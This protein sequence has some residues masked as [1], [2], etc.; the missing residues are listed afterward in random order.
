MSTNANGEQ[1]S[2]NDLA[3]NMTIIFPAPLRVGPDDPDMR[4]TDNH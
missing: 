3:A 4:T 2:Y 1:V